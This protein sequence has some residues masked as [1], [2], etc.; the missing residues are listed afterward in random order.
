VLSS[1]D[2]STIT[3]ATRDTGKVLGQ[4]DHKS[5]M[6]HSHLA[7]NTLLAA[8]EVGVA[9]LNFGL[10]DSLDHTHLDLRRDVRVRGA[11]FICARA[12]CAQ[13][14]CRTLEHPEAN[15]SLLELWQSIWLLAKDT[16][17]KRPCLT[18][19]RTRFPGAADPMQ[20]SAALLHA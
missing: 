19:A 18:N 4:A 20:G 14:T 3:I 10:S 12:A 8:V 2:E 9:G 13:L 16:P 6:R 5:T 1:P 11:G 7:N 15:K 17:S